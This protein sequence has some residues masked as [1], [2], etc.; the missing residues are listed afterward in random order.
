M[1]RSIAAICGFLILLITA[2]PACAVMVVK[3]GKPTATIVIAKAALDAKPY[4][5]AVGGSAEPA[6]KIRLAAE[7]LQ[8]YIEKM[9]GAK[10]PIVADDAPTNGPL[11]L[12]GASKKT[13]GIDIPTGLT[14][15]RKEEAYL[16][17][18]RGDSLV[19]A[20]NDM[21]PYNGTYFAV[22]EFL[23][24]QGVRWFMPSEF[25][26]VVPKLVTIEGRIQI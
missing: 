24:R 20:G 10:L 17:S 9:T 7:D 25:G 22:A 23:N 26:E 2:L 14:S 16:I 12:V 5:P 4:K 19:L 8:R 11:I 13:D 6:Q 15:E 1:R 3:E 21:G 18:T